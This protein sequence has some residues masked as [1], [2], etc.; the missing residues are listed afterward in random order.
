MKPRSLKGD[1]AIRAIY[2]HGTWARGT[3]VSVG[4]IQQPSPLI[5]IGFRTKKGLKGAVERNRLKRQMRAIMFGTLPPLRSGLDLLVVAHPR[6]IP[7]PTTAI[8]HELNAL[9]KSLNVL[10]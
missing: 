3:W 10:A 1:A 6:T 4:V 7:A 8:E 5:H 2:R 9:C